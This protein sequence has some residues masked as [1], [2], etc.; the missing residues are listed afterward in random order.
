MLANFGVQW[1]VP[2]LGGH[3]SILTPAPAADEAGGLGQGVKGKGRLGVQET[4]DEHAALIIP[5][6]IILHH[7]PKYQRYHQQFV[8]L[9]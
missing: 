3:L 4:P 8:W 6:A 5:R 2:Y 1:N 7:A 9:W